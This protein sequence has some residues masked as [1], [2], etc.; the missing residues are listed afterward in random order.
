MCTPGQQQTIGAKVFLSQLPPFAESLSK[1]IAALTIAVYACGFIIVSLYHSKFGFIATSPFRPRILAAGVWFLFFIAIPITLAVPYME[2]S[3]IKIGKNSL[4]I[5]SAFYFASLSLSGLTKW[6][7]SSSRD[8]PFSWWWL[9]AVAVFL[10]LDVI[11]G[12]LKKVPEVVKAITSTTFVLV[13]IIGGVRR[14]VVYHVFETSAVSLWFFCVFIATIFEVKMR[15]HPTFKA[16]Y[17]TW[18]RPTGTILL[19]LLVFGESYYPHIWSSWGGGT[20]VDVTLYF[21]KESR[22]K[23]GQA[24][25]AQ[26]IEESDDGFYIV[27]PK[28]W[29]AI[30]VPRNAVALI[31]FSD[32]TTDS[33]LLRDVK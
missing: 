26:L 20:P 22:L 9:G 8:F 32:N 23:P 11:V 21:S 29:R 4:Y 28:E 16:F 15:S 2:A 14:M 7:T 5:W 31:Y 24:I 10:I 30:F 27:N 25:P 3:W 13:L 19:A 17:R 18:W 33:A 12:N 6:E 1:G